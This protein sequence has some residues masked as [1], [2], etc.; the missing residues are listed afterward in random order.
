MRRGVR[1]RL[2]WHALVVVWA[3]TLFAVGASA[4]QRAVRDDG[5]T[6]IPHPDGTWMVAPAVTPAAATRHNSATTTM[7]YH[8]LRSAVESAGAVSTAAELFELPMPR[9]S[10]GLQVAKIDAERTG[11]RRLSNQ[12]A[13]LQATVG[14]HLLR[15]RRS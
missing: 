12:I 9:L 2:S 11:D 8:R 15:G 13:S 4:Q 14:P 3:I 1:S 7:Y 5:V 10:D 6:V